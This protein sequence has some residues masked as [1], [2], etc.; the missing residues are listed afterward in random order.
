[1]AIKSGSGGVTPDV[2]TLDPYAVSVAAPSN[3]TGEQLITMVKEAAAKGTMANF[4][5]HGIGGDYLSVSK[6]AHE[7][8]LKWLAANKNI[9][10]TDTFINIMKYVKEAQK[11]KQ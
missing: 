8:L 10:W 3:V 6:E 2:R 11:T 4:T 1:V 7:E 9:Y 5:F